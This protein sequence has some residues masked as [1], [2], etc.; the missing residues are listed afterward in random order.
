[1]SDDEPRTEDEQPSSGREM[2]AQLQAMI[3]SVAEQAAPIMRDVAI[4]AAEL[5][6]IAGD[7]AGPLMHRAAEKTEA[8]GQRVAARSR[9]KAGEWRHAASQTEPTEPAEPAERAED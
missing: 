4:K 3:D 5:A 7:K 8:V 9:E 2:L 1:M 6:A